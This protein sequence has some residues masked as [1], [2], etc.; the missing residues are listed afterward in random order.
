PESSG[1]Q[2]YLPRRRAAMMVRPANRPAK[3]LA[4]A[5][6]RR[7]ARGCSTW[8][9]ATVRPAAHCSRPRRATSTSG[10]S[11]TAPAYPPGGAGRGTRSGLTDPLAQ[12][13]PGGLRGLLLGLLL[14]AALAGAQL[15]PGHP[16]RRREVL[17]VVR[18]LLGHHVLRYAEAVL[19]GELLQAGLPVQP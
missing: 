1:S 13:L 2:R 9:S 11:G 4:P 17:L 6:C 10:R 14:A 8:A 12:R 16:H 7:T 3:S 15:L 5:R 19:R 18:T